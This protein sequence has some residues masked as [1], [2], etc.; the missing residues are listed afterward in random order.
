MEDRLGRTW[1][2]SEY[3]INKKGAECFRSL[4]RDEVIAKLIDLRSKHNPCIYTLQKRTVRLDR[5][6]CEERPLSKAMWVTC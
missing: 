1:Y 2:R 3:R 5:Y 4:D 6:G